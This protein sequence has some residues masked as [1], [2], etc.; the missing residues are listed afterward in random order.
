VFRAAGLN[1]L[2]IDTAFSATRGLAGTALPAVAAAASGGLTALLDRNMDI[3]ESQRG[4]HTGQGSVFYCDFDNGNDS[5][6]DGTRALPYK[7]LQAVHDDLVTAG[8]HDVV[9]MLATGSIVTTHTSSTATQLSKRYM[10]VRGP[11]RDLIFTRSTNG[12]TIEITA[13]GIEIFGMQIGTH[14]AGSGDGINVVGADFT[15]VHECWILATR[16]DGIHLQ[17][18]TNSRVFDNHF[19]GT[20]V[21]GGGQGV[22]ISGVGGSSHNTLIYHNHFANTDGTAILIEQATTNDS[23][24]HHNTIHNSGAGGTGWG[25]DITSS[26]TNAQVHDNVF[27][28]NADGDI[29][30]NGTTSILMNNRGWLSPTTVASPPRMLDVTANGNAGIDWGNVENASGSTAVAAILAGTITELSALPGVSPS[31]TQILSWLYMMTKNGRPTTNGLLQ[32]RKDDGTVLADTDLT[33]NG[34]TFGQTK[35][36]A[37]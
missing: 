1:N 21:T 35:F 28:N 19:D 22:H 25:I 36:A 34:T 14:S 12:N 10:C 3:T 5:S 7:T 30:D 31:L 24:I 16:G 33:D 27:G 18:A 20:G 11:G 15:S 9:I 13:S 23:E 37:P 32:I 29:R 8:A 6:G 4:K 17:N 2:L 26:S